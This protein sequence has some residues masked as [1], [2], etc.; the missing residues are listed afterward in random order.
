MSYVM[1]E[2]YTDQ[3]LAEMYV[4]MRHFV[5]ISHKYVFEGFM[6]IMEMFPLPNAAFSVMTFPYCFSNDATLQ[7]TFSHTLCHLVENTE[8]NVYGSGD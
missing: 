1:L 8:K 5:N 7:S 3:R 4:D 2:L 6:I